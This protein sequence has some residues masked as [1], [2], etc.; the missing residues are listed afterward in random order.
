[1]AGE[2]QCNGRVGVGQEKGTL[3]FIDTQHD[4][5]NKAGQNMNSTRD[6]V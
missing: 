2:A 3:N 4:H 5:N 1:M 6:N